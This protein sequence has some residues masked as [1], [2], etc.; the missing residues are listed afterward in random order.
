MRSMTVSPETRPTLL[1]SREVEKSDC[2]GVAQCA[3]VQLSH[4]CAV[5]PSETVP[6]SQGRHARYG[7]KSALGTEATT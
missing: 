4:S 1:A 7:A 3:S 5:P 6:A 2:P